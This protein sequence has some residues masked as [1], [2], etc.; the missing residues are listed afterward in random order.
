MLEEENIKVVLEV[1]YKSMCW[2]VGHC[3]SVS[4]SL[5]LL[6]RL[7]GSAASTSTCHGVLLG[8]RLLGDS[9]QVGLHCAELGQVEGGDLLGLLDLL[10][11]GL[12]LALQLVDQSLH[13]LVVLPVLVLLVGQLLDVPLGL[14][15]VLLGVRLPPVLSV[16]LRL[17]LSDTGLHLGNGLLAAL[18][19]IIVLFSHVI[20]CSKPKTNLE[21]VLLG[22]V[23]PVGGVLDLGLQQLPVPVKAH[24]RVLLGSQLV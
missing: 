24:D 3:R 22:L 2:V 16:D 21:S 5:H 15:Q 20:R 19:L 12:D 23:N 7:D 1:A 17:K 10:L 6:L 14:A 11:V 18:S 4:S 8:L 9:Q 13:A